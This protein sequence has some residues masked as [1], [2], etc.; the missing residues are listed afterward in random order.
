MN[1]ID[2]LAFAL[3]LAT[4]L[5]CKDPEKAAKFVIALADGL[6]GFEAADRAGYSCGNATDPETKR[7]NL[8]AQ[9]SR[10]RRGKK[11][12]RLLSELFARRKIGAGD[13][14]TTSEVLKQLSA[15][16]RNGNLQAQKTLLEFHTKN[17]PSH[18][19]NSMLDIVQ[20]CFRRDG[21]FWQLAGVD[22]WLNYRNSGTF[23]DW[24]PPLEANRLIR[25]VERIGDPLDVLELLMAARGKRHATNGTE[26]ADSTVS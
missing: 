7:K 14:L 17:K 20:E 21:F 22:F 15:E 11:I 26:S 5:R 19:G 10:A 4:R 1:D 12:E 18:I 25:L 24:Q 9:A 6:P 8:A 13:V 3:N 23:G 16:A 2:D